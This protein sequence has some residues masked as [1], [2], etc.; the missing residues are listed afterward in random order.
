[1]IQWFYDL[2]QKKYLDSIDIMFVSNRTKC[3]NNGELSQHIATLLEIC[4]ESFLLV[5]VKTK[6]RDITLDNE[7]GTDFMTKKT[8][9]HVQGK[10]NQNK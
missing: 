1:M 5:N 10:L 8:I 3:T 9:E 7:K 4:I 6:M 2:K